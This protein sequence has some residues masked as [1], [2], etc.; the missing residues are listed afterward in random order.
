MEARLTRILAAD[1][2]RMTALRAVRRLHLP[3]GWIAAGFVR[4]AVWDHLHGATPCPP[5]GDVDVVWFDPAQCMPA[6]DV[7]IERLLAQIMPDVSWSV[8]NQ[9]R[10]HSRNGDAP[11]ASVAEAMTFW[12]ETATAVAVRLKDGDAI[13]VNA[14][15]GLK[16]LFGLRLMPTHAFQTQ[17][18]SVFE[19]RITSKRWLH[20]YPLLTLPV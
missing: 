7:G 17:K 13:E 12:P 6:Q 5:L 11:Y 9:T 16:D 3:D 4:D 8:K 18:R 14:P 20:R 19:E 10:M 2:L 1:P 15:L